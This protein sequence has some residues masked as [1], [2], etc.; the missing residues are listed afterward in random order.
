MHRVSTGVVG[1]VDNS[2]PGSDGL[3]LDLQSG[4]RVVQMRREEWSSS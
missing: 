1:L 4:L 3:M 2:C